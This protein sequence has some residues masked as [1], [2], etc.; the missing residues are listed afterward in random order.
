[1]NKLLI[2]TNI[3]SDAMRGVERAARILQTADQVLLSPV[4]IAE[5]Y[6]GFRQGQ[7]EQQN[8]D[9]LRQFLSVPRVTM[10]SI[11]E[12]TADHYSY[13]F[14]FLRKRGTPVPTNDIW[15]AASVLENGAKLATTDKHFRKI[16]GIQLIY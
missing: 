10:L 15:I 9:Q 11:T 5:L 4:V 16:P 8:R 1:M 7:R 6:S 13:L 14:S 2:D 12:S 3:Y